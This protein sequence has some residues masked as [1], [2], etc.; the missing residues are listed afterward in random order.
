MD[1]R[2]NHQFDP[3]SP[4]AAAYAD[5]PDLSGI[6]FNDPA[7]FFMAI[8][9]GAGINLPILPDYMSPADVRREAKE[10]TT[11]IFASHAT[12]YQKLKVLLEAWPDMP[13]THRPDFEAFRKETPAQ[14]DLGTAYRHDL[15]KLNTLLLL[16]NSRAADNEAT[17]LGKVTKALIPILLNGYVMAMNGLVSWDEYPDAFEWM[18]TW[19][20]LLPGEGILIL[21]AQQTLYEF[22]VQCCYIL[23]HGIPDPTADSFPVLP[24]P[25]LKS[26]QEITGFESLVVMMEEAPYRVPAKLDL[27]RVESL[28]A[29]RASAAEDHVWS[30]REDP[31]YFAE[32]LAET[33]E[34][35]L[36]ML[37]DS[38]GDT[39]PAA[40][41]GGEHILWQRVIGSVLANAHIKLETKYR[42]A[43]LPSNDLPK[44]YLGALL[45]FRYFLDQ[46]AKGPMNL[47]KE[48]VMASPP[49]RAFFVRD[50]DST[51]TKIV[52][53]S[54]PGLK[55]DRVEERLIWL[56]QTLWEDS[57]TLLLARL[58]LIVDELERLLRTE[59][60]ARALVDSTIAGIIGDLSIISVCRTQLDLYQPWANSFDHFFYADWKDEIEGKFPERTRAWA[61]MLAAF[62]NIAA[63]SKLGEPS[64][65][66]FAYPIEKRRSKD[67]VAALRG[68]EA[69]LDAFWVSVDGL[70]RSRVRDLKGTAT[71]RMLSQPR[72]LQR[73]P[74]WV[75]PATT[76]SRHSPISASTP[77]PP[78]NRPH[79]SSHQSPKSNKRRPHGHHRSRSTPLT[80]PPDPQPTFP[81]DP[82][83]LKVFRTLFFNPALTSSPGEIPWKDFLHAMASTGFAAQKLYGSVWQF[84]PTGLDVERPIFLP[85]VVARRYGRRLNRGYGWVGGREA[86]PKREGYWVRTLD[87]W[88]IGL[89][90]CLDIRGGKI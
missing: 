47:L 90:Q 38:L 62:K 23:L 61:Q 89:P 20:Q 30:L 25:Q 36:E 87:I 74:E 4:E 5:G 18:Y 13:T 19:K 39:H 37:K 77:P 31:G 60:R 88:S 45:R 15:S 40:K 86:V 70:L 10:R 71:E 68:A 59:P 76:K 42:T 69:N 58:P 63:V 14:R 26:D 21:E 66:R 56:L 6:D 29:A 67:N 81:L 65:G 73:T 53:R 49:L 46:A 27:G 1:L 41:R 64:G 55:M 48:T 24:A 52:A 32:Q 34:H 33:K 7:S 83:A 51:S 22:L 79:I 84:R 17:S 9:R 12:L 3:F 11:R 8:G 78:Q 16:L 35:R 57:H 75:E 50:S 82:R 44:E 72:V 54:K 85:M 2:Q 80:T 43:I 28:L